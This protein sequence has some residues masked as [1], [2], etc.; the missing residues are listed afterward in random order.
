MNFKI[1]TLPETHTQVCLHRDCSEEGEEIVRITAFPA[2]SGGPEPM[3]EK[4]VR[5]PDVKSAKFFVTDYSETSAKGFLRQCFEE[6]GITCS[7]F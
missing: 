3:L 2:G 4:V 5:F 7:K 6:E 1:I